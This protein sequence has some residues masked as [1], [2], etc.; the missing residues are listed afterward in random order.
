VNQLIINVNKLKNSEL[1]EKVE[2]RLSEFKEFK[3]KNDKEWFSELCF[4]L[5]T[6]NAKGKNAWNIQKQVGPD[7]FL[8]LTQDQ[9]TD[10]I[11]EN[12]H[13]FHNNKAKFIVESRK[14]SNIKSIVSNL[15]NQDI[16]N[17]EVDKTSV[18]SKTDMD[19]ND[20][21]LMTR[22]W[23]V[24]N[25]KGIGYKE[26]SHFL[27]NTGNFQVAILDRHILNLLLENGYIDKK[28]TSLNRSKYLEIEKIFN[29]LAEE[30]NMEP[31]E[32]DLYMWYMKGGEVLK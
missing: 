14:H 11:K 10:I 29:Q 17:V 27:R 6:A 28:L 16:R 2:K 4:C 31:A 15:M 3:N 12:K 23:L 24:N 13:R 20:R 26:S 7:G 21:L 1:R 9:I 32:L 8:N 22:D 5:L 18:N 19:T 25:V 30:L